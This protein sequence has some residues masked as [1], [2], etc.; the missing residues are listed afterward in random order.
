ME[1]PIRQTYSSRPEVE[2]CPMDENPWEWW[3]VF[4]MIC[5]Y[6]KKLGIALIVSHDLPESEEVTYNWTAQQ[7]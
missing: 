6:N 5:G 7:N 3:N 4:R 1:N 2:D